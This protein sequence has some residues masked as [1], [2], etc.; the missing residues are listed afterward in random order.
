MTN[1][2]GLCQGGP[3]GGKYPKTTRTSKATKKTNKK[4]VWKSLVRT[5]SSAQPTEEKKDVLQYYYTI[6]TT[7]I[8]ACSPTI[9]AA[10]QC[11]YHIMRNYH[12]CSSSYLTYHVYCLPCP[13]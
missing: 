5:S 10:L 2:D 8:H 3:E 1:L 11:Y 9:H 4:E 12:L 13:L 6:N 7:T